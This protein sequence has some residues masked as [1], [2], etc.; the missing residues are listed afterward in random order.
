MSQCAQSNKHEAPKARAALAAAFTAPANAT[1]PFVVAEWGRDHYYGATFEN[2]FAHSKA[3]LHSTN[4]SV[5]TATSP[6]VG[7]P[8]AATYYVGVRYEAAYRFETE[9][10]L[11][12]KQGS[13]TKFTR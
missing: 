5:G 2:T 10:T 1:P 11:T 12:V 6:P 7:I 4:T 3:L 13:A 9:F 8:K